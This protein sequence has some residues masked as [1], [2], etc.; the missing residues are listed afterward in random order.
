MADCGFGTGKGVNV[1]TVNLP[2]TLDVKRDSIPG[3]I[4]YDSGWVDGGATQIWCSGSGLATFGYPVAVLPVAGM[5]HVYQT[6]IQGVGIKAAYSNS[7]GSRPANIDGVNPAAGSRFMEWPRTS[8]TYGSTE[9]TPAGLYRVQ[10]I[11][12]GPLAT[13]TQTMNLP[14]PAAQSIYGSLVTNRATFSASTV[15]IAQVSCALTNSNII[16]DMDAARTT[17]FPN[18]GST[19]AHTPFSIDLQCPAGV[20]VSYKLDGTPPAGMSASMGVLA[21][22]AAAGMAAGVGV[23][24]LKSDGT[25]IVPLGTAMSFITTTYEN[26]PIQIPL[27]ARYYRTAAMNGGQVK[28]IAELTMSYQ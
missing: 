7:Y 25:T 28:A 22:G 18:V 9:Y 12:T 4:I 11:V 1:A 19:G 15:V 26:Q 23:Q 20:A 2:A 21:N 24:V 5:P 14:V 27:I 13:G 6:G 10:Y 8:E 17:D 16:V 3:T